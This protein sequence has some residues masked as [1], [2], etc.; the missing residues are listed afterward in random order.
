MLTADPNP[1]TKSASRESINP[2]IVLGRSAPPIRVER[3]MFAIKVELK[4]KGLVLGGRPL[5]YWAF[6]K[7]R[8]P[9]ALNDWVERTMFAIKVE[10]KTGSKEL[11]S[12]SKS[13]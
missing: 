8:G 11:C 4:T 9:K 12:R 3:T 2:I 5:L 7:F 13:N 1:L 10:L 6:M